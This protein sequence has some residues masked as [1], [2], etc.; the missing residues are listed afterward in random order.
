MKARV[1]LAVALGSASASAAYCP[2]YT[3]S[4]PNNTHSCGVEAATGTNPSVAEWQDIFQLV[5]QGPAVW[6]TKGPTVGNIGQGCGKPEPNHDVPAQFPC[7]VLKAIA[8]QE[9]LWQHFCAPTTPSDMVG[10]SSRTIISFDCGYGIGQVTSGMHVGETPNFDRARVASDPTYN[11]ATGTQILAGK[12]KATQCVGDNQP[13]TVEHWYT[14][15]WAYNGLAYS[16]NPSNPKHDPNR[17]VY[18]PKVGGNYA[19]QERVFGWVEHP[20]TAGHWPKV[21]L[22]Y[23]DPA[24]CGTSGSPPAL[25]EPDCASPTDCANH[26]STHTSLCFAG[27]GGAGGGGQAGAPQGGSAGAAQAG[28]SQAGAAGSSGAA[29]SKAGAAGGPAAGAGQGGSQGGAAGSPAAGAGQ[30]GA[31][32]AGKPGSSGGAPQAAGA[33]AA[34]AGAG[35]ATSLT[36]AAQDDDG[37]CGCEVPGTRR[38]TRW[39]LAALALGLLARRRRR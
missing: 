16:N 19:Y 2:C 12:W 32:E 31:G 28:A 14:A 21:A 8:M 33:P 7:E 36:L 23:P 27:G 37:G 29:G 4:S 17:G 10:K 25:P 34:L 11:M 20:P 24:D 1:L 13:R 35:G 18:D 22:A 6:G 38:E 3:Q 15:V 26:R 5:A 9:S 39:G 30:G